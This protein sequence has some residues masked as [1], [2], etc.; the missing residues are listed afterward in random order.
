MSR[1]VPISIV[2]GALS[3]AVPAGS[4][5]TDH[6]SERMEVPEDEECPSVIQGVKL[7][8]AQERGGVVLEF[9]SP[10]KL[11]VRDL[12]VLVGEAGAYVEFVTKIAALHSE[13]VLAYD[14]SPV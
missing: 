6:M 11:N 4:T 14:G 12:R 10:S 8:L 2:L 7:D 9:S 1:H 3:I 13:Q 5:P